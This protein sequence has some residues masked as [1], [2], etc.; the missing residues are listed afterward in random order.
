M[1]ERRVVV[2]GNAGSGKTTMARTLGLPV[3]SLDDVTRQ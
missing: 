2:Y 1:G 3:L